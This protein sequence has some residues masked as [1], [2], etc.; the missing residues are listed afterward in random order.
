MPLNSR[1][2]DCGYEE[3]PSVAL[4]VR[5]QRTQ[6]LKKHA[7]SVDEIVSKQGAMVLG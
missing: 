5:Q 7:K 2:A 4:E 6:A 1:D 3:I